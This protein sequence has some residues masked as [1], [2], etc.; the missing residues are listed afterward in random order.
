MKYTIRL[1]LRL[2][3]L[4]PLP[5]SA[6]SE[7]ATVPEVSGL[8]VNPSGQFFF[9]GISATASHYDADWRYTGQHL[10]R[11]LPGFPKGDGK[12]WSTEVTL[13]PKGG[14]APILLN[15]QLERLSDTSFRVDYAASHGAGIGTKEMALQL[16]APIRAVAGRSILVDG[17]EVRFPFTFEKRELFLGKEKI[18]RTLVLPGTNGTVT[19]EGVFS[20]LIQDS[21]G[22]KADATTYQVRL[23]FSP[24]QG[25]FTKAGLSATFR[26]A[27]HRVTSLSLRDAANFG[28][29]DEV[30]GDEQ[31]GWTDQGATNDLRI[32]PSGPLEAAGVTFDILDADSN[33]GRG[34]IVLG[35]AGQSFLPRDVDIVVP[36]SLAS[37]AGN[38]R[39][40]YLLHAAAW[41]PK[42]SRDKPIGRVLL[43][44]V[45]GSETVH[46]VVNG[47]DVGDWWMPTS[48][49]NAV[50]GWL[51]NNA[52]SEVGLYV[53]RIALSGAPIESVHLESNG[54]AM[55]M[56]AGVSVADGDIIPSTPDV[57]W[58]VAADSTW[59]PYDHQVKIEEGSVFD[60][61][62]RLHTPAG[63]YG[64][65][66]ATPEGHFEFEQKPGERQ[67]FWGVNLVGNSA[68]TPK[69]AIADQI[70]ENLSRSGYNTVRLH[71]FDRAIQGRGENSGELI[72][73]PLD[74]LDYL[75]YALKQRGLY[76]S[77]DLY[78]SRTI[79]PNEWAA[80]GMD[81]DTGIN[82]HRF[83]HAVPVSEEAFRIWSEFAKSLLT[84]RNPYT[85]LT[86][87][88]DPALIGICLL[89]EDSTTAY[90]E[91]DPV[92]APMWQ[93]AFE[94]WQQSPE[95]IK[96]AN[97]TDTQYFNRFV[98]ETQAAAEM[99]MA[100]FVRNLGVKTPLTG[101]NH[102]NTQG[103]AFVR[104][105]FDYVDNH[106]YWGHP[107]FPE[108]A[109]NLPYQFTQQSSSASSAA[110]LPRDMMPTRIIGKPF[111]I[112]EFNFVRPQ[113]Y[114]AEGGVLMPAYAGLQD[115]DAIYNF[116]YVTRSPNIENPG[117]VGMFS[118]AVDPIGLLADRLA[119]VIFLR[120]DVLPGKSQIGFAVQPQTAFASISRQRFA[121]AFSKI[122]LVTRIGSAPADPLELLGHA[123]LDAVVVDS[124]EQ[125]PAGNALIFEANETLAENLQRAGILPQ[126]AISA[127][128]DR[129]RSDTGQIELEVEKS[130]MKLV[131]P[132]SELFILPAGVSLEGG[133]VA[134]RNVSDYGT[135]AV[136]AVDELP[137]DQS[138]RLLVTHLTDALPTGMHFSSAERRLMQAVGE[139]PQ[140]VKRGSAELTLKLADGVDFRAWALSPTGKR[141]R[142]VLLTKTDEGWILHAKTI[143]DEGTQMA[144][145]I[146]G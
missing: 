28:F 30:E 4:L 51:D 32:L 49:S 19:V 112:T 142:E 31:G 8:E 143:S 66:V 68:C 18:R 36:H 123:E 71:H 85:G 61:S 35:S 127:D 101:S 54:T 93:E 115:W 88:E 9:D 43:R 27:P 91:T 79:L 132:R 57:P 73:N 70:A 34:A 72:A 13:S 108:K 125:V 62:S 12:V 56:V 133:R 47:R 1:L 135:V 24:A 25:V 16:G 69:K 5:L 37:E 131:T 124:L 140:L 20:V 65:L 126:G 75:F 116:D 84:H 86:W 11:P 42:D 121:D 103:L 110:K 76:V 67:R 111:A 89:N 29:R 45:D 114:R 128:G 129:Y 98:F 90:V 96:E 83:R 3:L 120:G 139:M 46:E 117:A 48:L 99:R 87:G 7:R 113:R 21:R 53:S 2:C 80:M 55:W 122:G 17:T 94:K 59:Q 14:G 50:V 82:L 74:R 92:V 100:Q 33:G 77:I 136:V 104:Q 138:R 40:I 102:L 39:N 22:S 130:A 137:I 81:P 60:F 78:A 145:E 107:R 63:K 118:L 38:W 141:V 106:Q 134:V 26:F 44:H 119:A 109:W 95:N 58:V 41:L 144:Y 146:E 23:R 6:Q 52:R 97:E 105:H 15:E 64:H 10:S